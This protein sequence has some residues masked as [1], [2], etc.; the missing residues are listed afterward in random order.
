MHT[1]VIA[2]LTLVFTGLPA[3]F[4]AESHSE[5]LSRANQLAWHGNWVKAALLYEQAERD[6]ER[7]GDRKAALR[8][9]IGRIRSQMQSS[10]CG[11]LLGQINRELT[12]PILDTE[13]E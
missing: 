2:G 11:T 9:R 5:L 4:L 12:D 10:S 7:S 1:I 3:I 13:H 8:A 6:L